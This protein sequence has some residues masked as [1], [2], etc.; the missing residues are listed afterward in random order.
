MRFWGEA[1]LRDEVQ[2][3]MTE[4]KLPRP[5]DDV[6]PYLGGYVLI[7]FITV[8]LAIS[9]QIPSIFSSLR[10]SRRLYH[11][12]LMSVIRA[13]SRWFDKTP[14]GR[15]L[16]RFSKDIDTIDS[17]LQMY[18][19]VVVE[20]AI[21]AVISVCTVVWGAP[22]F[23]LPLFIIGG[24]QYWISLGYVSVSRDLRRIESNT[25]SP[26]I[27][28]FSELVNGISTV[29]AFGAERF[30][31]NSL[32]KRLD[33]TQAAG[34][35]YWMCN[36][37]LLFR[38]DSLG[39]CVILIATVMSIRSG[40]SPGLTGII[41]TQAQ[42]VIMSLY[43]MLRFYTEMEQALNSVERVHEYMDVPSEPPSII[44]GNRPPAYWP[45][46]TGGIS[47]ENLVLKYSPELEPV[48]QGV[49]FNI[50]PTEKIGLVGRT[51][52]GKSTL[53]LAFFRFV[54]PEEGKII[55]DGIDIT[56][57]GLEDLRS[58]LTIIPQDAVLF[59]GT[60]RE[61]LD[62]FNEH[63]D[64]D[65]LDALRRV[66]LRTPGS[67]QSTAV[68]SR[69]TS[70]PATP[71]NGET[72]TEIGDES[73]GSTTIDRS[74]KIVITLDT[75]VSES[76][77]NFSSGQRQLIAM[78]RALLRRSRFVVMDESTASVDFATDIKI[79]EA[80]RE[81]F[82][83]SILITIAHRLRTVIDY[84]RILVIDAGE[85]CGVRHPEKSNCEGGWYFPFD[86]SKVW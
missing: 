10:A 82:K 32:F 50:K 35:Y 31:V 37:W 6:T 33:L 52:S 39:A 66:Q 25:R 48:L 64:E 62:P 26:I 15:I 3:R 34:Y 86:V 54:D 29:R 36:R 59:A 57:I 12:M 63:S 65:C 76:G 18:I 44:E 40:V 47:V 46:N 28:S 17:G 60:I 74:N 80:I 78:A 69:E 8:A 67:P 85:S 22:L 77:N 21:D 14:S 9:G 53:A 4:F 30:F 84:D 83:D 38:F 27:S 1:Y 79:Q 58:R 42:G 5:Q 72:T 43:W 73:A 70:R 24:L 41:I 11:Q 2:I 71:F 23:A 81:E 68:P 61:N 7:Q 49:S 75:Q 56:T 55:I 16:N 19:M 51:G 45:S 13:P 20:T